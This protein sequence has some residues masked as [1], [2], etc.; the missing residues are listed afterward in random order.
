MTR[1]VQT[2]HI[3]DEPLQELVKLTHQHPFGLGELVESYERLRTV[4]R[5]GEACSLASRTR[6]P[7]HE[8][9][10]ELFK[11]RNPRCPQQV[12]DMVGPRTLT[13]KRS[14]PC[15]LD[16]EYGGPFCPKEKRVSLRVYHDG[17][18]K[19]PG[20]QLL[21]SLFITDSEHQ[22]EHD[23]LLTVFSF[24]KDEI[25]KLVRDVKRDHRGD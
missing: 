10:D 25:V 2:I 24:V 3:L 20:G 18:P 23:V 8:A 1:S 12:Y 5:V 6:V 11:L 7:L 22:L 4:D 16:V 9:T 17:N 13:P 19:F 15:R 21:F 14:W